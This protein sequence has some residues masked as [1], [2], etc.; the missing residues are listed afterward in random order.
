V[1]NAR[2]PSFRRPTVHT[3]PQLARQLERRHPAGSQ[4]QI[5]ACRW[6]SPPAFAFF[7]DLEFAEIAD[8]DVLTGSEGIFDVIDDGAYGFGCFVF[9]Y[10][11]VVLDG[12]SEELLG[13]CRDRW[14][15]RLSGNQEGTVL[16]WQT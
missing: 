15:L 1:R 6:I 16:V 3:L 9:G 7:L 10:T 12:F 8:Q 13:Q 11:G 5:P 4:N 14:P 2:P